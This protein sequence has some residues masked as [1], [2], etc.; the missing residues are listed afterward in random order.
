MLKIGEKKGGKNLEF[1]NHIFQTL[2]FFPPKLRTFSAPIFFKKNR[3]VLNVFVL[4]HDVF[5]TCQEH[6]RNYVRSLDMHVQEHGTTNRLVP[7][8]CAHAKRNTLNHLFRFC[9][10]TSKFLY[11]WAIKLFLKGGPLDLPWANGLFAAFY[12]KK[13]SYI[14]VCFVAH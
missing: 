2:K 7:C 11:I 12:Y 14:P 10:R 8:A 3:H 5:K 9:M 4:C 1:E 13:R 6:A